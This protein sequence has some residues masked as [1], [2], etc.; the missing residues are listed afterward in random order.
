[1]VIFSIKR[2]KFSNAKLEKEFRDDYYKK[3]LMTVRIALILGIALYSVFGILDILV[4]PLSKNHI[5]FIRFVLVIPGLISVLIISYFDIFRKYMQPV[6]MVISLIAGLGIIAMVGITVE[7][8]V[9][10]YYYAG[11]MLVMMWAYTFV[12]LR[13]VYAAAVGWT[14]VLC[15]EITTIYFQ[16]MLGDKTLMNRFINNNFFFISSNVIGMFAG[17]LIELY[18]RKDFIQRKEI[19][20]KS[21]ELQLER[22]E[23]KRREII[24]NNEL[25]MAR[26]IQQRLIPATTPNVNIFSFYKPMEAVG[27]DFMDFIKFNDEKK[28]GIFISDV[29]GHG[30]PAALIT[31]MIK[32]SIQESKNIYSDPSLL[33]LHLNQVL[34]G[35]SDDMFV[36]AFYCIYDSADRSIVYSN[37]GHHPPVV[38]LQNGTTILHKSKSIPLTVMSNVELIESG[39]VYTNSRSILPAKSKILFYTDGLIEA[40]SAVHNN[41]DFDKNFRERLTG[42]KNFKCKEFTEKLYGELV[43]FHGSELFADDICIIC[44]DIKES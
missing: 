8:E 41:T 7:E 42:L 16:D 32:G 18:T 25:E 35:Q 33:L 27:G 37:A 12:K 10:L 20:E 36:T 5:L 9:S 39:N 26:Q 2:L 24:M 38:I 3:S 4:A 43:K 28:I 19:A 29:S 1:M 15:Y 17:Y 30:V 23:L 11:L 13:F 34:S 21:D 40:K 22:N 31:S 6:L 14:I 44:M